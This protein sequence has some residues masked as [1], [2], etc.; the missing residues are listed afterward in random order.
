MS[1]PSPIGFTDQRVEDLRRQAI[2]LEAIW[3]ER[4]RVLRHFEA[5]L[6]ANREV[7]APLDATVSKATMAL[8]RMQTSYDDA[9]RQTQKAKMHH[10]DAL[11]WACELLATSNTKKTKR[12][13]GSFVKAQERQHEAWK[14]LQ[15][16]LREERSAKRAFN[17]AHAQLQL[18]MQKRD[19]AV[20]RHRH[21]QDICAKA[22]V[23]ER[24]SRDAFMAVWSELT[25]R[26]KES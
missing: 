18:A 13:S 8:E 15:I 1:L 11:Q 20:M 9:T 7:L 19:D 16:C 14:K 26:S 4:F 23:T 10:G 17:A 5:K 24:S 3:K 12:K 22:A 25:A 2:R 21:L 6:Q